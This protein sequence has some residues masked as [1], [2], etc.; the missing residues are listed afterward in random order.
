MLL[1]GCKI[2]QARNINFIEI[3]AEQNIN[4]CEIFYDLLEGIT[5]FDQ[6]NK[7]KKKRLLWCC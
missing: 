6:I 5:V 3:S 7:I 2:D 1:E 4:V